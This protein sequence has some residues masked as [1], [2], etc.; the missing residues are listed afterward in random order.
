VAQEI[1]TTIDQPLEAAV[2][3]VRAALGDHGF[4]VLTGL[5]LSAPLVNNHDADVASQAILGV[6]SSPIAYRAGQAGEPSRQL[7]CIVMLHP[8]G[9]HRTRVEALDPS[10]MVGVTGDPQL[11]PVAEEAAHRLRAAMADLGAS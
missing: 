7:P 4:G 2:T 8:V 5:D 6:C 11:Q 3:A 9:Q 10:T 1:W